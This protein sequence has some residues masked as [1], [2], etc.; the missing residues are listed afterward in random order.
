MIYVGD[1][2]V[3]KTIETKCHTLK[4]FRE[5][6]R[7]TN[8]LVCYKDLHLKEGSFIIELLKVYT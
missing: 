3:N 2:G 7:S 8:C 4:I 6:I 1:E 5:K